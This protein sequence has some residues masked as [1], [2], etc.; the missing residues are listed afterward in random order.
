MLSIISHWG[1]IIK[2]TVKYHYTSIYKADHTKCWKRCG[3]LEVS[4]IA[5]R[6]IKWY[7][8]CGKHIRSFLESEIYTAMVNFMCHLDLSM[9]AQTFG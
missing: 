7:K 3:R 1:N 2:T 8:E 6:N 5:N 9:D 4:H